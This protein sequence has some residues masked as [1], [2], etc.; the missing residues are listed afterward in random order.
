[1]KSSS[2][3]RLALVPGVPAT[4]R[5]FCRERREREPEPFKKKCRARRHARA[6]VNSQAL[7]A[8]GDP[9]TGAGRREPGR[10][11]QPATSLR[12]SR[13]W[14]AMDR[15]S[16]HRAGQEPAARRGRL[17]LDRAC[18][19]REHTR[20]GHLA[21][22]DLPPVRAR[23]ALGVSLRLSSQSVHAHRCRLQDGSPHV[24]RT[25]CAQ[26]LM[27]MTQTASGVPDEP[28]PPT[29][30]GTAEFRAAMGFAR[31]VHGH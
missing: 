26:G 17:A 9:G 14:P 3:Q 8:L 20:A 7:R 15:P 28:G 19:G 1:M 27:P 4:S 16:R 10:I 6:A 2:N 30:D 12:V 31:S 29:R 5:C 23:V 18:A 25:P 21:R 22:S 24:R 13:G 11:D